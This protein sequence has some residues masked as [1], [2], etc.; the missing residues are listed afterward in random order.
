MRGPSVPAA[1]VAIA[2]SGGTSASIPAGAAST[3]IATGRAITAVAIACLPYCWSEASVDGRQSI[4]EAEAE[5]K[6]SY[7]AR[8]PMQLEAD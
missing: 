5:A 3:V 2:V 8:I 4:V 6:G 7:K 1:V